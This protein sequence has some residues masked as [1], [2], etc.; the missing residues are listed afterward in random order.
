MKHDIFNTDTYAYMPWKNGLGTT[1]EIARKNRQDS[2]DFAWRVSIADVKNDGP[3]SNY[4][5]YTRVICTLEGV[6]MYLNVDGKCS[7]DLHPYDPYVFS[8]ASQT[9]GLLLDGAIRDFNL[10]YA[11][12][13][14]HARFQW[15]NI[16]E[17]YVFCSEASDILI[18]SVAGVK[19]ACHEFT[20]DIPAQ[21]TLKIENA[22]LNLTR[23]VVTA[24]NAGQDNYC[25]IIEL[26]HR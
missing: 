24:D 18:Y 26:T 11:P 14:Y 10:I 3:F 22:D 13:L 12:D 2:E 17:P 9:E 25:C 15:V 21:G 7:P 16:T 23:M 19:A 6:G 20:A 5:G 1:C 8:G 4:N